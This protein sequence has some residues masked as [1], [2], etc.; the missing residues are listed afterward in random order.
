[1]FP[2]KDRW[3]LVEEGTRHLANVVMLK[4][5]TWPQCYVWATVRADPV[6]IPLDWFR[7]QAPRSWDL[8]PGRRCRNPSGD[9]EVSAG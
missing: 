7:A 6:D 5:G 1:M 9:I 8:N 3:R 2:F 4:V